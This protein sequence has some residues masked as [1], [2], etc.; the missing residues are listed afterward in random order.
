MTP[1][2]RVA[3]TERL[4]DRLASEDGSPSAR[5]VRAHLERLRATLARHASDVPRGG[6][7]TP[8][9]AAERHS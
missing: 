6:A 4:D 3:R 9:L 8:R 7:A 1:N 5:R 2:P